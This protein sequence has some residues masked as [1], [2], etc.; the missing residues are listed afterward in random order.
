MKS[1]TYLLTFLLLNIFCG[2]L[3]KSTV[4]GRNKNPFPET[5]ECASV[6]TNKIFGGVETNI[7]EFPWMALIEYEKSE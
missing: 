5:A 7:D 1:Q 2:I 3:T 6:I 4:S